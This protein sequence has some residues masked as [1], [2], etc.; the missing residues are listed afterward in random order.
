MT[1]GDLHRDRGPILSMDDS[2]AWCKSPKATDAQADRKCE[3]AVRQQSVQVGGESF[4][5]L[6]LIV[7]LSIYS[8]IYRESDPWIFRSVGVGA[9]PCDGR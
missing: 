1:T 8:I 6:H 4:L 5:F 3:T 9:K 7:T 2:N